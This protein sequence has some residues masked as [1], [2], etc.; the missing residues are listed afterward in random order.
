MQGGGNYFFAKADPSR[1]GILLLYGGEA[2]DFRLRPLGP[3]HHK[4]D[5]ARGQGMDLL[6]SFAHAG[7]EQLRRFIE[8]DLNGRYRPPLNG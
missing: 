8:S 6:L 1:Q 4:W 5:A 3:G 7:G 2:E